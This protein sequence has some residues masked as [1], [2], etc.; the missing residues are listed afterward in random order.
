LCRHPI[1]LFAHFVEGGINAV[2]LGFGVF[3]DC[4]FDDNA[5]LVIDGVT[6]RHALNQ[7]QPRQTHHLGL[8]D[9]VGPLT[10]FID[11][12]GVGDQFA[13]HHRNGLQGFDFDLRV[14]A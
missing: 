2:A 11:Q 4:V 10:F 12:S 5:W 6:A 9:A 14:T 1:D 13:Q 8:E 3:G 7:F